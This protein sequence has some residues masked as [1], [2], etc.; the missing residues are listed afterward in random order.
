MK[1]HKKYCGPGEHD[2]QLK[3]T[4]AGSCVRCTKCGLRTIIRQDPAE[5]TNAWKTELIRQRREGAAF[6]PLVNDSSIRAALEDRNTPA[7]KLKNLR[8]GRCSRFNAFKP[9]LNSKDFARYG[10]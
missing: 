4:K 2:G 7:P 8:R 9:K 1:T 3:T 6:K 10:K 5:C